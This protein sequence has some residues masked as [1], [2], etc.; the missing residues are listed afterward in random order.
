MSTVGT[1]IGKDLTDAGAEIANEFLGK[2]N[3]PEVPIA[4]PPFIMFLGFGF[5]VLFCIKV[6]S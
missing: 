4:I 1:E 5:L 2:L 6:F 3:P